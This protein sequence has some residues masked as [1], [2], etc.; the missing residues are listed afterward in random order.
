MQFLISVFW[1]KIHKH[2]DLLIS[3]TQ[4]GGW[5]RVQGVWQVLPEFAAINT[6]FHKNTTQF[7]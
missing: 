3:G 1:K 7:S 4:A 2:L 6:D 5:D